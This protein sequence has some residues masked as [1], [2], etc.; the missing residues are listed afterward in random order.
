MPR[1]RVAAEPK[2][3]FGSAPI[4]IPYVALAHVTGQNLDLLGGTI[5]AR[6]A[7][8]HVPLYRSSRVPAGLILG[9]SPVPPEASIQ[10]C[11][12]FLNAAARVLN[13]TRDLGSLR[14]Q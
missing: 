5:N 3:F 9:S 4:F 10:R 12:R 13:E 11:A 2:V 8:T 7:E 1:I 6:F 14:P